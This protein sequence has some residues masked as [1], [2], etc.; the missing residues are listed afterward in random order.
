M[1]V[2]NRM[3]IMRVRFWRLSAA[4]SIKVYVLV[5]QALCA[6]VSFFWVRTR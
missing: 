1:L 4:Y 2:L 6:T 3:Q 5:A